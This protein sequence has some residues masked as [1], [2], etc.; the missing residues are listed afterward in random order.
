M[1]LVNGETVGIEFAH[2]DAQLAVEFMRE[3]IRTVLLP[4]PEIAKII[5]RIVGPGGVSPLSALIFDGY[6]A[7]KAKRVK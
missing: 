7:R 5:C 4:A 1:P 3:I 2:K 6:G